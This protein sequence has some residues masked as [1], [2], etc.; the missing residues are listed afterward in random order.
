MS[1]HANS[2][3]K[4]LYCT[5]WNWRPGLCHAVTLLSHTSLLGH[6]CCISHGILRL[7]VFTALPPSA[8][9]GPTKISRDLV[10]PSLNPPPPKKKTSIIR[11]LHVVD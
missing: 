7:V 3:S 10:P 11:C 6:Q 8:S 4:Q 9:W 2:L 5:V 1:M